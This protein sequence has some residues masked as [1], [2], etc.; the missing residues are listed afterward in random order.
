[1]RISDWSSDVCS[2]DLQ[3]LHALAP[4]RVDFFRHAVDAIFLGDADLEVAHVALQRRLVI[5][6]RP[7]DAGRILREI[8][9]ASCRERVWQ[10]VSISVVAVSLKKHRIY[11]THYKK[12]NVNLQ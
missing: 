10:Y 5:R 4:Q 6:Y 9:S 11:N 7:V 2:S 3:P 8:G 1:M 12:H